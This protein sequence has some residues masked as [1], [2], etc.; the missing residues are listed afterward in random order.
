MNC[1]TIII[2]GQLYNY[3]FT[4][5]NLHIENSCKVRKRYFQGSLEWI[6]EKHPDLDVWKRTKSSLRCEWAAHNL[7]YALDIHRDRT[8][9]IDLNYPQKWYVRLAYDIVGALA[10]LI[11][12]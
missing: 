11:I 6:E 7:C 8:K 3:Q 1:D 2:D 4:A 5:N 12:K 10:L 9:D